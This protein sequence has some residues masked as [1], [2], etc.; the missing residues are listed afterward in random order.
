MSDRPSAGSQEYFPIGEPRADLFA[1]LRRQWAVIVACGVI[2]AVVAAI[3]LVA[4]PTTFE[5][6]SILLLV[7]AGDEQSPGGGRARTLDVETWSTVARSTALLQEV[8]DRLELDLGT[9]R[10]QSTA[11]AAPTGDVLVLAFEASD[12]NAAVTGAEVYSELFLVSR[13]ATINAVT[14]QRVRR[15]QE[16]SED[17]RL[18]VEEISLQIAEEEARGPQAS[19][20]RLAA[21]S[22][23][24][25]SAIE[26]FASVE[27]ELGA[28][29]TDPEVGRVIIEPRTTVYRV[30]LG[31]GIVLLS[32]LLLGA[33]T[34][35][36]FA[37]F[38]NRLDDRY[39]SAAS[40]E[41]LGVGEIGRVPYVGSDVVEEGGATAHAY[42]R[43]ISRLSFAK[44]QNRN[45]EHNIL[46]LPVESSTLPKDVALRVARTLAARGEAAGISISVRSPQLS[47]A[48]TKS[49][50]PT[51]GVSNPRNQSE[52][53]LVSARALDLAAVSI[54]L[55][56]I[57]DETLLLVSDGTPVSEL[58][59]AID[60]LR[61]MEVS[62]VRIVVVGASSHGPAPVASRT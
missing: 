61:G 54:G 33:L 29:D 34:G 25:R 50:K 22:A 53:G 56:T 9:V 43:L 24:Q 14:N 32:G 45:G 12:A 6:Q 27:T 19:A 17:L 30:G 55:A 35:F 31:S 52:I 44:R 62:E 4:R 26:R 5:S 46:L 47:P 15:L 59:Q 60:D 49:P 28:I 37:L 23:T 18:Q 41:L 7:A 16:F 39:R 10:S 21:L 11:T 2:G 40:P 51:D 1:I 58:R 48:S 42:D 20:S 8:A 13:R 38:R 57:A 36:F 3:F